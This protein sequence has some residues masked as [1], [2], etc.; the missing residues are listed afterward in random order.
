VLAVGALLCLLVFRTNPGI[1]IE[2]EAADRGVPK[3]VV[4]VREIGLARELAFEL[5][6]VETLNILLWVG[7]DERV[8]FAIGDVVEI[9]AIRADLLRRLR[10]LNAH[11]WIAR[12]KDGIWFDFAF[13]SDRVLRQENCQANELCGLSNQQDPLL[14]DHLRGMRRKDK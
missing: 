5:P 7:I 14:E 3:R 13:G 12:R 6:P 2:V 9:L 4:L 11:V 8:Q 10:K 1:N